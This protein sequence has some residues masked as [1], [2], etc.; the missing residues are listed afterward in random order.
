MPDQADFDA[1]DF[2]DRLAAMSDDE[3]FQTIQRLEEES[4]GIRPDQRDC[5]DVFAK[6]ALVETAIED[7]LPGQLSAPYQDWHRPRPLYV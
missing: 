7:R 2:A 6:I 3:M 5:S 1:G 4:E